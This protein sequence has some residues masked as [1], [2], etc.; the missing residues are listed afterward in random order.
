MNSLT[1]PQGHLPATAEGLHNF[2]LIGKERLNSHKAKLRAIDKI[3]EAHAAKGAA[4][5]DAQDLA[6]VLLDAEAR[7]G[8]MLAAVPKAGKTK[9]YGSSGG[10]IPTLPPTITKKESH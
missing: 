3:P 9:E 6:D 1:K 5:Q 2:I 4:L 10:T 8:G 7:L